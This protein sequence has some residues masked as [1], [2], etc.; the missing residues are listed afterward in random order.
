M[1]LRQHKHSQVSER[2]WV[3]S[4]RQEAWG[5]LTVSCK[6]AQQL[7]YVAVSKHT[8]WGQAPSLQNLFEHKS[9]HVRRYG[10]CLLSDTG[11]CFLSESQARLRISSPAAAAGDHTYF[12]GSSLSR[13]GSIIPAGNWSM[14]RRPPGLL[15]TPSSL[16]GLASKILKV[17]SWILPRSLCSLI[18][19]FLLS[20]GKMFAHRNHLLIGARRK[21]AVIIIAIKTKPMYFQIGNQS[22]LTVSFSPG[23][24][25]TTRGFA[26]LLMLGRPSAFPEKLATSSKLSTLAVS[27]SDLVASD[28]LGGE[29]VVFI[30]CSQKRFAG[31]WWFFV[32]FLFACVVGFFNQPDSIVPPWG[33]STP[34]LEEQLCVS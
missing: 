24:P 20:L 10:V 1:E 15:V 26:S 23:F 4:R 2:C 31:W 13:G 9:H 34:Y 32:C 8:R 16:R 33:P 25:Q 30:Y 14:F 29:R 28:Q 22:F 12:T 19:C 27:A 3:C 21:C 17:V 7:S 11:M 5:A 6:S 18:G